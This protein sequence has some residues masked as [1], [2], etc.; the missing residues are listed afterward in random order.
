MFTVLS[1]YRLLSLP[2]GIV[3]T[4]QGERKKKER[5][6]EREREKEREREINNDLVRKVS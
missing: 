3:H 6:R 5:E 1:L 4:N 2:T